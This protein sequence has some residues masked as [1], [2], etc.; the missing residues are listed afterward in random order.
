MC[1]RDRTRD[2]QTH[3][4]STI[5]YILKDDNIRE[6]AIAHIYKEFAQENLL[7]LVAI[8]PKLAQYR[9]MFEEIGILSG[10]AGMGRIEMLKS[11][12]ILPNAPLMINVG[13]P[14]R[15]AILDSIE[16]YRALTLTDDYEAAPVPP[17]ILTALHEATTDIVANVKNSLTRFYAAIENGE[18]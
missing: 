3:K 14:Q 11:I 9:P 17:K 10:L 16:E 12:F 7:Y 18:I 1:I 4:I 6:H 2:L 15:A 5:E 13:G 8:R